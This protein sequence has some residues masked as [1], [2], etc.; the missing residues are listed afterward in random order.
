MIRNI[1][2]FFNRIKNVIYWLP[3][4]WND[5]DWGHNFFMIILHHKLVSMRK[6]FATGNTQTETAPDKAV[7][8]DEIIELIEKIQNHNYHNHDLFKERFPDYVERPLSECF[9]PCVDHPGF[10]EYK[11][12]LT[13]EQSD[14]FVECSQ[15]DYL[16]EQDDYAK[17]FD[18]LKDNIQSFWD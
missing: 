5:Q 2:E 7:I 18:M 10:M 15:E 11:S 13:E 9:V 14:F 17:I 1:K 3:V 8:I 6:F 12:G 4:I 16:E